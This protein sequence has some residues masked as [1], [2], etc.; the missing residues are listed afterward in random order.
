MCCKRGQY[1]PV[2]T[3]SGTSKTIKK[4]NENANK[5]DKGLKKLEPHIVLPKRIKGYRETFALYMILVKKRDQLLK[6]LNQK[7]NRSKNS[8]SN[9]TKQTK[10]FNDI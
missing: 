4:R 9:T 1:F 3:L 10:S 6:Y 5:L 8:L 7:K 2:N